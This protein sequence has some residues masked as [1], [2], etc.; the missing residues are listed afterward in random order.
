MKRAGA[1]VRTA[2]VR[3]ITKTLNVRSAAVSAAITIKRQSDADGL[4]TVHGVR[5]QGIPLRDYIGTRQTRKGVSV[6]VLKGGKRSTLRAAFAVD[7]AGGHY[8]GRASQSDRKRYG[9]PHVGRLPIVKLYGPNIL[10]QYIKD[11]I[12]GIG[13]KTWRDRIAIELERETAF[14]LKRAGVI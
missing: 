2:Q 14:A 11:T 5:A 13:E 7:K 8:F 9:S 3:E 6:K 10:S 12:Q 4:Q 1:S